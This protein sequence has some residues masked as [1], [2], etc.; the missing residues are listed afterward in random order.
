LLTERQKLRLKKKLKSKKS[1]MLRQKLT[2]RKKKLKIKNLP[3]RQR[4][5]QR[6]RD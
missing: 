4:K 3:R 2:G 5:K 1:G 6:K